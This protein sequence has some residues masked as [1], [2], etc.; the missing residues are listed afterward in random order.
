MQ[1]LFIP[2]SLSLG[3]LFTNGEPLYQIPDYQRPYSWGDEQVEQLW[4]DLRTAYL[5]NKDDKESDANYFLGSLIIAKLAN[6][7]EDVVDGQQRLT[8]L[9]I[10]FNVIRSL[11][12]KLNEDAD[13][14]QNP[15]T[16]RIAK[17]KYCIQDHNETPRLRMY[18]HARNQNDF[19]HK[20][21][22][23]TDFS[24]VK[25]P[26]KA[27]IRNNIKDRFLNT[28]FIFHRELS[29]MKDSEAGDFVN[30]LFNA[31]RVIKI[32][33]SDTNS[34]VKLFQVLNNRGLDLSPADLIKSIL[35][36]SIEDE[37]N[38]ESFIADWQACE[39]LTEQ[40]DV[41]M[42]EFFT[43]YLY[44][45]LESNP[46]KS[47]VEELGD[48]FKGKNSNTII[49]D[50]KA[51]IKYY[52][53]EIYEEKGDVEIYSLF[54]MAWSTYWITILLTA[55]HSN[56]QDYDKL[57]Q[58]L[59]R[60]YYLNWIAGKTLSAVKQTSF[61]VIGAVKSG[62]PFE[63]INELFQKNLKRNNIIENALN[64]LSGDVY[65]ESWSK[66]L[67]ALI[68]FHQ[69]PSK[70]APWIEWNRDLQLEHVYPQKAQKGWEHISEEVKK[71]YLHSVGNLTL[72]SSRKNIAAQNYSFSEKV[73]IYAGL[74]HAVTGG[75]G[76]TSFRV[77][78]KLVDDYRAKKY[79]SGWS[80]GAM[81][82]RYNWVVGEIGEILGISVSSILR[83]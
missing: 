80:E 4:D 15:K 79:E 74:K 65:G 59:L 64:S 22:D 47:L 5:N 78:Q 72:L 63:E 8:T 37:K 58:G 81:K 18:L 34:A 35:F 39:Q 14:S 61:N 2:T 50:F 45:L 6:G 30:Y 11:F 31:V 19:K 43:Y 83:Q 73:D 9:V 33:C 40:V 51:F 10:L 49:T 26:S 38:Q 57:K 60:Y 20:I 21:I 7:F 41:N 55:L 54:Y 67:F 53:A 24:V 13:I 66:P 70:A 71:N 76:I 48:H 25:K 32:T 17:V 1:D 42:T 3:E 27:N 82:D 28:A 68:E 44:Y 29:V 23:C 16:V 36:A 75:D 56:Y 62:Q 12:P 52:G 69:Y 46:K 77:S